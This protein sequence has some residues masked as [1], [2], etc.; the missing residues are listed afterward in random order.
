MQSFGSIGGASSFE[1][2]SPSSSFEDE[3]PLLEGDA[4]RSCFVFVVPRRLNIFGWFFA[5]ELGINFD[6]IKSKTMA[7]LNPRKPIHSQ[8]MQDTDLAGPLFFC[9]LLG[10]CLLLV[11]YRCHCSSPFLHTIVLTLFFVIQTGKV[12]F[13]YIYGFGMVGCILLYGI[14]NLMSEE[15]IDMYR[16][17]SILGYCL[18]PIVILAAINVIINLKYV[19][20]PLWL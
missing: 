14:L 7:V 16:T 12:H 6:H 13:G 15:G 3:P 19:T 2:S 9:L 18:L 11:R 17:M 4:P 10:F 8:L 20:Y 1:S 5:L